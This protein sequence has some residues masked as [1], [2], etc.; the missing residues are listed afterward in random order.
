MITLLHRAPRTSNPKGIETMTKTSRNTAND[1][2]V[3]FLSGV[4][5]LLVTTVLTCAVSSCSP[6]DKGTGDRG[7]SSLARIK[8]TR[9]LK[10]AYSGFKPY[11]IINP[12]EQ[13]PNKRVS[14]FCVD[15]MKE[16]ATR[17]SPP[18]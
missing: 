8:R 11:T 17:Q 4:A 6:S 1:H 13:D 10:A 15:L 3:A 12:N 14:G 9:V 5:L 2:A 7:E 16:M 18:W